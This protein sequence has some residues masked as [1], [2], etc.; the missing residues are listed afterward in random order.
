M[1]FPPLKLQ[2]RYV[3]IALSTRCIEVI[4]FDVCGHFDK[5]SLSASHY[6]ASFVDKF[7]RMIWS[8]IRSIFRKFKLL[9]VK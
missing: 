1:D 9:V 5:S 7:S 3:K 4:H 6:F 8:G 2:R